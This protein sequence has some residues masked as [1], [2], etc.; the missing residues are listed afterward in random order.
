MASSLK[1]DLLANYVGQGW[2]ALMGLVFIPTYVRYLGMES[3]GLIGLFALLQ[4]WLTLLD[5]G[6]SPVLSREMTRMRV[7]SSDHD[8][9]RNL[10]RG[11]E[12]TIGVAA[13]LAAVIICAASS[14]L[15]ANW[16]R[17]ERLP[18]A[19]VATAISLMGV[20]ASVRLL[21]S[22]YRSAAMGQGK[23]VFVNAASGLMA[24]IRGLGCVAVLAFIS[25]TIAAFFLW[26]LAVAV[27]ACL[28]LAASVYRGLPERNT[29]FSFASLRQFRRFA[30]GMIGIALLSILLTQVDK[31]LLS[32]L[33]SLQSYGYYALASVVASAL[34]LVINPVTQAFY[35]RFNAT[36]AAADAAGVRRAYHQGAQLVAILLVPC[37]LVLAAFSREVIRLWTHNDQLVVH[38]APIVS[39]LC[40]GTLFNGFMWIPYQMQLAHGHTSTALRVNLV[41]LAFVVPSIFWVTPRFGAT[42]AAWVW[43]ALNVGY[44]VLGIHVMYRHVLSEERWVWYLKDVALP[45]V[46]VS[47]IVA[48]GRLLLPSSSSDLV[49]VAWLLAT[50]SAAVFIAI[51]SA[52]EWRRIVWRVLTV[53]THQTANRA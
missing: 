1:H 46:G 44:V 6:V 34:Y 33:L 26:Q 36:L 3:Y 30:G 5:F 18:R 8:R 41:A 51:L 27:A 48:L 45:L 29:R 22:A 10:L 43:C 24:T 13:A 23:Q 37:A 47:A 52:E 2:T 42:G 40:L 28:W 32:R 20:L 14:W 19:D 15:A 39:A 25:P 16:L 12:V 21:E 53:A 49:L 9:A 17:A 35:P 11:A 38:V 7:G 31:V 50:L 4:A